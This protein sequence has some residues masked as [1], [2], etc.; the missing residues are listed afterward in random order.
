PAHVPRYTAGG[1]LGADLP[2]GTGITLALRAAGAR[3]FYVQSTDFLTGANTF[4]T[5]RLKAAAIGTL[6]VTR[7]VTE[8]VTVWGGVENLTDVRYAAH[9]GYDGTDQDFP[10]PG[11]TFFAGASAAW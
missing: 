2:D 5:R 7:K 11:R 1:V 10:M 3:S 6:R 4:S 8:R 9:F